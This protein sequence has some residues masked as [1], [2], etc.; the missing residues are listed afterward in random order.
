MGF[1]REAALLRLR[2]GGR[3]ADAMERVALAVPDTAPL[4]RAA[5]LMAGHGA[6]RV[7]V[8]AGDGAL[9]GVLCA[10]D[11]VAWLARGDGPL[12]VSSRPGSAPARGR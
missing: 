6:D 5:A 1:V 7:A 3:V 10:L 2:A 8:V 4:G 11:V 12:A 9:V